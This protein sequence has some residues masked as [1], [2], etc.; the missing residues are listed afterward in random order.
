MLYV[1]V[2]FE[3][4]LTIDALVDSYAYVSAIAQT[5]LERI[6]QQV[7]GNIFKID[8]LPNSQIQIANGQLEKPI[9]TTTLKFDIGDNTFAEHLVVMKELAGPVIGLHLMRHNSVAIDTTHGLIHFPHLTVQT[10]NAAFEASAK[11]QA[12]LIQD[13]TT[14][15]PMTTKTITAIVDHPS[16]W[17][18]AGTV[19][20]LRKITEAASLLISQSISTIF[21]TKTA[22]RI[23]NT[24]ESP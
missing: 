14:V 1:P 10:K 12:V 5:E 15:P 24:T 13:N 4:G 18:T 7:P 2:D 21:D 3:D 9:S 23:T 20:P 17:H 11:P 8:D 22:V 19:T 16:E 6:K